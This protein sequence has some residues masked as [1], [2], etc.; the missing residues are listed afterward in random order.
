MHVL[1]LPPAFVLSQDQTL[2]LKCPCGHIHDVRT[3][4]HLHQEA[5]P[6]GSLCL[7]CFRFSRRKQETV[8]TVKLTLDHRKST[9][10][11]IPT[12]AIYRRPFIEMNQT[13]HISLQIPAMSNSAETKIEPVRPK[14]SARP[15][16]N[17]SKFS[18]ASAS[19]TSQPTPPQRTN[20]ASAPPVKGGLR[21]GRRARK[22]FL[23]FPSSFFH[24]SDFSIKIRH[25]RG[26]KSSKP[27]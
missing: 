8:Q 25:V 14:L 24:H 4:A 11:L 18:S 5:N 7:S 19:S 1:S 15:P 22:W 23:S 21:N 3:S 17:A 2:K 6:D 27:A 26:R 12:S 16:V 13:A 10:R 9:L 20:R